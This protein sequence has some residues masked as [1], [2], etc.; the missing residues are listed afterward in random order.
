MEKWVLVA[1][2]ALTGISALSAAVNACWGWGCG[3]YYYDGYYDYH[4]PGF[5]YVPYN[6]CSCWGYGC[7][8]GCGGGY[9]GA[10]GGYGYSYSYSYSYNYGYGY[11]APHYYQSDMQRVACNNGWC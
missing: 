2:V 5:Y 11:R 8:Y 4:S 9:Y 1:L 3:G 7:G 6:G 10:Y